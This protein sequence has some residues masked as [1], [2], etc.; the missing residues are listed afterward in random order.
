MRTEMRKK[1]YL[2]FVL[3]FANLSVR[4]IGFFVM[5]RMCLCYFLSLTFKFFFLVRESFER[6][7]DPADFDLSELAYREIFSDACLRMS[8]L[9]YSPMLQNIKIKIFSLQHY[10]KLLCNKMVRLPNE[11]LKKI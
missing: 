7:N 9:F 10:Q 3:D 2:K 6:D 4:E 11:C 1:C 8:S 5:I